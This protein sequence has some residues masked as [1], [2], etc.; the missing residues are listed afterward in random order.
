MMLDVWRNMFVMWGSGGQLG[1]MRMRLGI[2]PVQFF[3]TAPDFIAISAKNERSSIKGQAFLDDQ[4][5]ALGKKDLTGYCNH[6][7]APA[8]DNQRRRNNKRESL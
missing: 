5:V 1:I 8:D 4:A 3:V 6:P 7:R 2:I